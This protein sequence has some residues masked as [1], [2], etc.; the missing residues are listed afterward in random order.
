MA[1]S[2]IGVWVGILVLGV[3][4]ALLIGGLAGLQRI[5]TA[6]DYPN[7]QVT[8][9]RVNIDL[10]SRTL[11]VRRNSAYLTP[12]VLP[13]LYTYYSVN[14][15]LGIERSGHSNCLTMATTHLYAFN[16][17]EENLAVTICE[18]PNGRRVFVQR[19]LGVRWP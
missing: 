16:W 15:A 5:Y 18:V 17:F 14:F 12:D 4:G 1:K 8:A 2:K 3:V 10:G 6:L 13:T 9:N 19:S 11:Q 7:A